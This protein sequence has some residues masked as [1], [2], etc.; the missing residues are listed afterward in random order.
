LKNLSL[1]QSLATVRADLQGLE[2][3]ILIEMRNHNFVHVDSTLVPYFDNPELL[4]LGVYHFFEDA[5]PDIVDAGNA[6]CVGLDTA[7]VFHLMRVVELGLR[8]FAADLGLGHVSMGEK[9]KPIPIEYAQWETILNQLSGKIRERVDA[10]PRSP[11]KQRA[12]EFYYSAKEE[13]E[14]FRDA[15]RN[16]VSHTRRSYNREDVLAVLCHVKRF[17]EKLVANGIRAPLDR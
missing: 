16:H 9:R 14:G 12:Q 8:A 5:R 10:I 1:T 13:I 7:A 15:W 11:D 17:M 3:D 2:E 4:G 6:L